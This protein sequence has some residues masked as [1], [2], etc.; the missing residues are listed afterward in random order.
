[1]RGILLR[2]GRLLNPA[3]QTDDV[4]DVL[5]EDGKVVAVEPSIEP[6]GG[7]RVIDVSG[8]VVA[9]GLVDMHVHLRDPG[10]EDEETILTGS[11]A[12]AH[13]G[14]TSVAAMPNTEPAIDTR[15]WVEYVLDS[16]S[17]INVHPIAA[18]TRRREGKT[19]TEMAELAEAGAV[20]FSDD[21]SPVSSP[22]IMRRALEYSSMVGR[23]I[24]AHC[25][26]LDLAGEGV[27]N[28]GLASTK[29]GLRP[30]PAA[31]E[32]T[33]VARDIILARTTGARLH[34]AHVSTKGSV[35]LVRRAK[36]DGIA[37]TCETCPHY[38]S[39]SDDDVRTYDTSTRVNP[40]L[41]GASD[42][43]AIKAGLADGTIDAIASDHAPHSLEEKQVEFDAA[44][45]GMIGVETLLP[46]TLTNLVHPGIVTLQRAIELLTTDPANI[47]GIE[48]GSVVPGERADIVVFDPDGVSEVTKDWLL[49]KSK[50]SPFIGRRLRGRV[51]LTIARG[52]IVFEEDEQTARGDTGDAEEEGERESSELSLHA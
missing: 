49:S 15:S 26:D 16:E 34:I 20:A 2:G 18:I 43:S 45:P 10:R 40:P 52:E 21:G 25:E 33:M 46:L 3:S 4:L 19:L 9:P 37:V 7:V 36:E 29:A 22:T 35:E 44:P 28:E 27:A 14:V 42:V 50:N 41:R 8:L 38:F 6:E 12:A 47:L 51:M 23:P 30:I 48:A 13:G 17:P 39:L 32:E 1:M 11:I 31:A 24:I 5:I